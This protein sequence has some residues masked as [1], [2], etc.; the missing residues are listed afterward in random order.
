MHDMELCKILKD[1]L[2]VFES[3]AEHLR[4]RAF[5]IP[6]AK[7]FSDMRE[8]SNYDKGERRYQESIF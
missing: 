2:L 5:I 8:R 7:T 1:D 6:Y 3:F 4:G